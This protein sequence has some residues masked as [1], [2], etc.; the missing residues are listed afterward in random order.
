ME[1]P[2][3]SQQQ[4]AQPLSGA[5]SL[6]VVQK[7]INTGKLRTLRSDVA[8]LKD[9]LVKDFIDAMY[10]AG[11]VIPYASNIVDATMGS[12]LLCDGR[13]ISQKTYPRLFNAIGKTYGS[14]DSDSFNIPNLKGRCIMGYCDVLPTQVFDFGKWDTTKQ[15][16]IG[17]INGEYNHKV[18][19]SEIPVV[20][21]RVPITST[22][23]TAVSAAIHQ[24][25]NW[26]LSVDGG[27][28]FTL[29]NNTLIVAHEGAGATAYSTTINYKT[30]VPSTSAI[31]N[32]GS[33]TTPGGEGTFNLPFSILPT[34]DVF[35]TLTGRHNKTVTSKP[36]NENRYKTVIW[37]DDHRPRSRSTYGGSMKLIQSPPNQIYTPSTAMTYTNTMQPY[38]ALNYI[39]KY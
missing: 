37:Y 33:F 24:E 7:S 10:P 1:D 4:I 25:L 35:I 31:I 19:L 28:Y 15:V 39:I 20:G 16:L 22:T 5:E 27:N 12:W 32:Q 9:Y 36:T 13:S 17:S 38:M 6:P 3:I 30:Y 23:S 11:C 18:L 26:T 21:N 29:Q 14:T 2:R 34:S 8:A